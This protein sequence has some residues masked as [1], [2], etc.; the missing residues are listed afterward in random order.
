MKIRKFLKCVLI[1]LI[2][3]AFCL[4][5]A[6]FSKANTAQTVTQTN[7][8]EFTEEDKYNIENYVSKYRNMDSYDVIPYTKDG[9]RRYI[10]IGNL[11]KD[12]EHGVTKNN[13]YYCNFT[14]AVNRSYTDSNGERQVDFFNIRTWRGIAESCAKYLVKGKKVCVSGELQQRTYEDNQGVKRTVIEIQA[15]EVEFLSPIDKK[16]EEQTDKKQTK[17]YQQWTLEEDDDIPF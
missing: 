7:E 14:I 16:Q 17:Q 5:I 10:L 1:S 2:L 12:T 9:E 4:S 11:T 3:I 15:N 8:I 6:A 13:I